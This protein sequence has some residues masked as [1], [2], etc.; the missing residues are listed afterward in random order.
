MGFAHIGG[1]SGATGLAYAVAV[2]ASAAVGEEIIFRGVVFRITEEGFGTLVALVLSAT[3]FGL[4]H[5]FNPGASPV[6]MAAIALEAGILLALAYTATRSLWLPIGLHFGW[7]FTEGGVFGAPVSGN[8]AHGLISSTLSGDP[9]WTGGAF[10][11]EAS[12]AAVLVCL[13][14]SLAFLAITVRRGNWQPARLRIRMSQIAAADAEGIPSS[15]S[16]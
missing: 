12:L 10:G 14:A 9:L 6:S 5:G 7:N 11:P 4:L 15:P 2:A 1:Y 8:S 16:N 3:L 13:I